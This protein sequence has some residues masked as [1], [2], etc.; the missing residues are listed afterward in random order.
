MLHSYWYL[1]IEAPRVS[2][3]LSSKLGG[4]MKMKILLLKSK[5]DH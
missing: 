4:L 1:N 2:L 5:F 3:A